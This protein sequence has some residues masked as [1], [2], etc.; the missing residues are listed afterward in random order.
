MRAQYQLDMSVYLEHPELLI[1]HDETGKDRRDCLR[2]HAYSIRGQPRKFTFR[3]DRVNAVCAVP[4]PLM[5]S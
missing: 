4:S 5:V 1:F 2:R 3:G